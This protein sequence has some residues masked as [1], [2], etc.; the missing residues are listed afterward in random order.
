MAQAYDNNFWVKTG[1]LENFG[2]TCKTCEQTFIF[3]G[4]AAKLFNLGPPVMT[5][6]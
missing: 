6:G 1:L 3:T 4:A 5:V 2:V